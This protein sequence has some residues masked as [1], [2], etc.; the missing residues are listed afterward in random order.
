LGERYAYAGVN[1]VERAPLALLRDEAV[2]IVDEATRRGLVLRASGGIGYYLHAH[3]RDLFEQLGRD[4]VNDIDLVGVSRDRNDYKK[5]FKDLDYDVDWD[6]L[7]AGEGKRFLF[8]HVN[9][10][11]VAV[12]LFID[13]LDM[14][15]R[16]ELRD[17]LSIQAPT[18]PLVDLLL[19]KLQI[20]ELNQKDM[21]DVVVLLAEHE[22]DGEGPETIDAAYI[23]DV[24]ADDWGFYYTTKSNLDGIRGYAANADLPDERRE[25]VIRRLDELEE[26]IEQAPK[27][28]RWRMRAR[29]GPKK[30]WY[31][32]VEDATGAF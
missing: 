6:L 1:A 14:C 30:K 10:P 20:V 17:R 13:R 16:I 7:V 31:Q 9:D 2:R 28:R 18:I 8:Q 5:L 24:L 25:A 23:A 4:A 12:D 29:L 21:V 32:D 11:R 22:L 3:D 15:H 27:S 19:Q 26:V